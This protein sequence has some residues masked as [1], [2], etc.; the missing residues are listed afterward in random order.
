MKSKSASSHLLLLLSLFVII[1]SSVI[2]LI[3]KNTKQ[4]SPTSTWKTYTNT[5]FNFK[6][7]ANLA[8]TES[9][10]TISLG[11]YPKTDYQINIS[12]SNSALSPQEW[13]KARNLCPNFSPTTPS[14]S[15]LTKGPISQSLQLDMLNRH[16]ASHELFLNH[17]K[18]LYQFD[19]A[20]INPNQAI[21]EAT[22]NLFAQILSTFQFTK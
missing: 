21:P 19:L 13:I 9:K 6:Y 1:I 20:A 4:S 12:W 16:Y 8:L 10:D 11:G 17:N 7:P 15:S 2:F 14:C 18:T 5:S 3:C 22:K